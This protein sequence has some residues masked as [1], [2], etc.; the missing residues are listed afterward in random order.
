MFSPFLKGRGGKAVAAYFGMW[1]GLTLGEMP[2]I[3]GLLM[4]LFALTLRNSA[5]VVVF[6]LAGGLAHLLLWHPDPILL[7]AWLASAGL[8]VW[9]HAPELGIPPG[10]R[11]IP[12]FARKPAA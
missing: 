8:L 11:P 4:A 9:K 6:T 1:A 2:L 12:P 3:L 7:A 10:L 5:W